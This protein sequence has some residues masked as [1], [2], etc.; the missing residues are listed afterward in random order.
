M[1]SGSSRGS[2]IATAREHKNPIEDHVPDR[3][4]QH[5]PQGS[6]HSW[7]AAKAIDSVPHAVLT[8]LWQRRTLDCG[9]SRHFPAADHLS[10]VRTFPPPPKA[11]ARLAEA[12]CGREGGRSREASLKARTTCF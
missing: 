11:P 10:A 12:Y 2:R 6:R 4:G 8:H 3:K 7:R 1:L 5:E 9:D